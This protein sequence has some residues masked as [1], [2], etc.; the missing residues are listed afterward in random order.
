MTKCKVIRMWAEER[1]R[2][3]FTASMLET[4]AGNLDSSQEPAIE[5]IVA[6]L[7]TVVHKL[8]M[9]DAKAVSHQTAPKD[10]PLYDWQ[11]EV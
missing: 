11:T 6:D 5:T 8:H 4:L 2:C 1:E 9:L 10:I 7:R 3:R